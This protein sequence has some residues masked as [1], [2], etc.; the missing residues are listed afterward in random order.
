MIDLVHY[1]SEPTLVN[2]DE[3]FPFYKVKN[4]SVRSFGREFVD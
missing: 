3:W 2:I 1:R 4:V